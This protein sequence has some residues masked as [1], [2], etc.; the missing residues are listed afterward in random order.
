MQKNYAAI[1]AGGIGS[2]F[3]P[4]SRTNK[5]KQFLDILGTGESLLQATYKR[6]LK[7]CNKENIFILTNEHYID[8]VKEQ[9]PDIQDFQI[10]AEPARKNTAPCIAYASYKIEQIEPNANIIVAPSDHI[11]SNEDEF[12]R[13]VKEAFDFVSQNQALCTLGIL[14]TR[15]DTGYGYIQYREDTATHDEVYKVKTFT[16]KPNLETAKQF[17]K[18]GDFLWN[19]GI[20]IWNVKSII[21]SFQQYLHEVSDAFEEVKSFIGTEK[22][23]L[24]IEKAF[25]ECPNISIDFGIME[26]A[27]NVFVIPAN[28][29]WSDLGTW[30]SLYAEKDKDYLQNAVSGNQV[31]IYDSSNNIINVP[32]EKLVVIEGLDNYI[33]VDTK[34]V[35]LI[36]NKDHEQKIKEFTQDIKN[37]KEREAF[38]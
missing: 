9:L 37:N 21:H 14:P 3:W 10:L 35:L 29:G 24:A 20:F 16:E 6:F 18:S 5:P 36:C 28:F 32:K 26:K 17:I 8:L 7:V 23:N 4:A 33:I 13:I 22:E 1:M 27:E 30:A 15:P 31:V 12:V 38:L 34:D 25:S 19:A 11:I 2:R